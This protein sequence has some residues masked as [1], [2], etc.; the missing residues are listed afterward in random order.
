MNFQ[1]CI[2][3]IDFRMTFAFMMHYILIKMLVIFKLNKQ[4][5][6][7]IK[8]GELSLSLNG[9]VYTVLGF[10]RDRYK[11]DQCFHRWSGNKYEISTDKMCEQMV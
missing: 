3:V 6:N 7:W 5:S 1:V 9:K 8:K 4:N 10:F 2:D 11:A